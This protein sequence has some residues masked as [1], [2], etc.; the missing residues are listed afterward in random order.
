LLSGGKRTP[1]EIAIPRDID[2]AIGEYVYGGKFPTAGF[3]V[4]CCLSESRYWCCQKKE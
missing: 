4:K 1:A 2:F 3:D